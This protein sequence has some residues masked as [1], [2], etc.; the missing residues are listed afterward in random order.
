MSNIKINSSDDTAKIY[1]MVFAALFAALIAVGAYIK[2]PILISPI[3][4]TL[5][6]F[7]VLLAAVTLGR[8]WG[9]VS[10]IVYLLVGFIGLPVFA[11]G[12]SGV[13]VLLGPSGGYL[14]SFVIVAFLIGS[15]SEKIKKPNPIKIFAVAACGSML[16]LLIGSIHLAFATQISLDAAFVGGFLPFILG[17]LI[18]AAAVGLIAPFLIK[19]I[20]FP[21]NS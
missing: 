19:K 15:F 20:N 12:N 21:T 9:T 13:G 5:Q 3:P 7:F 18:K 6:V 2:I 4:I 11:G 14:Y 10:I 17:D 16:V 1:K 8:N